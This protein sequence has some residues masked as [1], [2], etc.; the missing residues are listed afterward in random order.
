MKYIF[1]VLI[2]VTGCSYISHTQIELSGIKVKV[3]FGFT[4]I[5]GD[6]INAVITRNMNVSFLK[7]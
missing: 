7:K 4:A 3:P 1:L 2:F 6:Q 5:K